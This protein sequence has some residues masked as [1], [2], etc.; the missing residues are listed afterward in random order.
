MLRTPTRTGLDDRPAALRRRATAVAWLPLVGAVA[1]ALLVPWLDARAARTVHLEVDGQRRTIRT[2]AASVRLALAEHGLAVDTGDRVTPRLDQA[3]ADGARLTLFRAPAVLVVAD[4]RTVRLRGRPPTAR[5][6]VAAAGAAL[7]AADAVTVNGLPWPP[8]APWPRSAAPA[9]A[10]ARR[11]GAPFEALWRGALRP[12][13]AHAAA[14]DRAGGRNDAAGAARPYVAPWAAGARGA[15]A[16]AIAPALAALG[17]GPAAAP[18][19]GGVVV[20][21]A[22]A[23]TIE[24]IE[25]GVATSLDVAGETVGQALDR[26]GV[27]LR[28]GDRVS[29]G[30]DT[31]LS[32]ASRVTLQRGVPMAVDADGMTRELRVRAATVGEALATAGIGLVGRDLVDPPA[33][34]PLARGL[35]VAVTRVRD[36]VTTREVE[37]PYATEATP[38]PDRP[39]D[40]VVVLQA[41]V[42]GLAQQQVEVTYHGGRVVGR[43]VLDEVV[44]REPVAERVAYGTRIVWGTVETEAGPRRY[45]RKLRV[46]ATSYSAARAGTPRSAPWYGRTRIGEIMRKGIV[47]TDPRY[48]PMRTNLYVEGYGIGFAGDTGGGVKRFHID[49]GYDD[50]NYVSWHRYVDVYLLEPAPPPERIPWWAP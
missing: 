46:Y 18:A 21:V 17:R 28:P 5:A 49:L 24:V 50:D 32:Y 41:G 37:I 43:R 20:R 39:L 10:P 26:A 35:A 33:E 30:R 9:E 38:D 25:D 47:A 27:R 15:A 22:R 36:V 6:A 7:A 23:R 40:D 45:W 14:L 31:P 1:I 48:I 4:G 11:P 3:L 44:V 34:T 42:P 2:T 19:V 8:D 12:A 29:P 13:V 16:R